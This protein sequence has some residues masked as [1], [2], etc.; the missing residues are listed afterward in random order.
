MNSKMKNIFDAFLGAFGVT[1]ILV[2]GLS[3]Y[4]SLIN[5]LWCVVFIGP[6]ALGVLFTLKDILTFLVTPPMLVVDIL[7]TI[8]LTVLEYNLHYKDDNKSNVIVDNEKYHAKH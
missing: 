2:V 7:L 5:M 4:I 3:I 8:L 6:S 1:I